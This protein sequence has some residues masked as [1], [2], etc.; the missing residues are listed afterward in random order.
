MFMIIFASILFLILGKNLQLNSNEY[1][2][3]KW[4]SYYSLLLLGMLIAL[5]SSSN[6]LIDR[7]AL[8]ALPFYTFVLANLSEL[9]FIKLDNKYMNAAVVVISFLPNLYGLIFH[10]IQEPGFHI[11]IYFLLTKFLNN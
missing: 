10:H 8:Y 3:G 2:L 9:K 4:V 1:L 7:L 5:P 6:S 11:K